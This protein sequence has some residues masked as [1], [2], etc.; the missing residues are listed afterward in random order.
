MLLT[1][2]VAVI[3]LISPA[4]AS[5]DIDNATCLD[6]H[7][8]IGEMFATTAHGIYFSQHPV[9][10]E[11]SCES[12]HGSGLQHV[13]D[14][15]AENIINPAGDDQFSTSL[16]LNCHSSGKFENW[17]MAHH[18]TAD[19]N[20][21]DCHSVHAAAGSV[22]K[23]AV[24]DLCYDC[25]Q[26]VRATAHM[27]SHHPVAE[28]K[29]SCLDCHDVHGGEMAFAMDGT[30]KELCFT[31]HADVEGPFVY[32]HA[33]VQEDCMICHTPHGSVA[34]NL[35]KQ[36]QPALCLNCHSMHFHAISEGVD[37]SFSVPMAPSRAGTSQ[38]DSWKQVMLTKCTQCH[39]AI[40]GSDLP[41]QAASTGGKA[42]TR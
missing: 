11:Y 41:S 22:T 19:I 25:H 31:C 18:N 3:G 30:G 7:E 37:G 24:P 5:G 12:C 36:N 15:S 39:S 33:P 34:D 14:P 1:A 20:C 13:D 35:L 28:G 38:T 17:P 16:C 32:E 21:A 26:N 23:R 29:M 10:A 8:D 4:L 27:P 6:C 42:L 40:H 9:R 2:A